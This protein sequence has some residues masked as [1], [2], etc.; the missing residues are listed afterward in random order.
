MLLLAAESELM[1]R[2]PAAP[3][4]QLG[5][6]VRRQEERIIHMKNKCAHLAKGVTLNVSFSSHHTHRTNLE[7]KWFE[8]VTAGC[9]SV[10]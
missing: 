3:A 10:L 2:G 8:V 6:V 4:A 9:A 1:R 5:E 7:L